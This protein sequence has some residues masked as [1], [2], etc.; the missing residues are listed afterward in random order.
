MIISY[1][2]R[3][4]TWGEVWFDDEPADTRADCLLYFQ[5]STP[6]HGARTKYF[7]TYAIDLQQ[8]QEQM[9]ANLKGD[10]A[11]R[12]R[13][14]REQEKIIC[15]FRV[16]RDRAVMN[17]FEG[18]YNA[19]AAIKGLG[20]LQRSRMEGMAAAGVL[21]FSVAKSPGGEVLVYHANYRGKNH[22]SGIHS[23]SIFREHSDSVF[24]NMIS[25]ANCLLTWTNLLHYKERGLESYDF[26]GWH[27]GNDPGLLSV[28]RFKTNF[29]GQVVR[30]YQCEKIL[31]LK[32]WIV[33]RAAG[34]L[35]RMKLLPSPSNM[36]AAP[37]DP[38][39]APAY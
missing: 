15:E 28:N 26:G 1:K 24:R 25:R 2:S 37:E 11:R 30:N 8:S 13:R 5:R 38:Q 12:I 31:T 27:S 3:F 21:D 39:V 10:T 33:L 14:A 4:L 36:R 29:G 22:A 9:L 17:Q 34:L 19:F 7:Y 6:V 20:P 16:P 18:F 35:K 32:G 23:A